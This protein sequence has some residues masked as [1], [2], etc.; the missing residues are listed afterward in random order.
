MDINQKY[1]IDPKDIR[2]VVSRDGNR[3]GFELQ[4][5]I[6]YYR[7]AALSMIDELYVK[8]GAILY[9][10]EQLTFTVDGFSY[11]WPQI[12]TVTTFRWEYGTKATVFVPQQGGLDVSPI[13]HIEVGCSIRRSYGG[14]FPAPVV[15]KVAVDPCKLKAIRYQ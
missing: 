7:G 13:Q 6:P 15:V 4:L 1:M 2:N 3:I 12:E 9:P 11:T 14:R 10:K 8:V 5:I